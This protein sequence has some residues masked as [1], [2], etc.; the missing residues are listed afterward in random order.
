MKDFTKK[1]GLLDIDVKIPVRG[2]LQGRNGTF[3]ITAIAVWTG[4]MHTW[5]EGVGKRGLAIRGGFHFEGTE[6]LED[7]CRQVLQQIEANRNM[8]ALATILE[9]VAERA[10]HTNA[11][12]SSEG[13]ES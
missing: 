5:I 6:A 4:P 10:R 8:A 1:Q 9:T 12:E 2:Y 3:E 11:R 13:G 7:L